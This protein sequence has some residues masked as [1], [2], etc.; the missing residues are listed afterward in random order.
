M[1]KIDLSSNTIG[2]VGA[3]KLL[4]ILQ[5]PDLLVL[6]LS[7]NQICDQGAMALTSSIS[8]SN[9]QKLHLNSNNISQKGFVAIAKELG[10]I[11]VQT[12]DKSSLKWGWSKLKNWCNHNSHSFSCFLRTFAKWCF[13]LYEWD[14]AS[15]GQILDLL[16]LIINKKLTNIN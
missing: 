10:H 12:L 7:Y 1:N 6:D 14:F 3:T 15:L 9:I 2:D 4:E 13:A 8:K 16:N 11:Q 5:K